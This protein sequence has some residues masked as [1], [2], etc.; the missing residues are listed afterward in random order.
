MLQRDTLNHPQGSALSS[1]DHGSLATAHGEG[2]VSIG[3]FLDP[4]L[5]SWQLA[6]KGCHPQHSILWQQ[7]CLAAV[8][9][10]LSLG[11]ERT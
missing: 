4:R 3:G 1:V 7:L 9:I 8:I 11:K 6:A 2:L 5:S 10:E